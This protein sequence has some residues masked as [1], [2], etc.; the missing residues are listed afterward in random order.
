VNHYLSIDAGLTPVPYWH[1]LGMQADMPSAL[2]VRTAMT[3]KISFSEYVMEVW[4]QCHDGLI[5]E[6]EMAG[7]ITAALSENNHLVAAPTNDTNEIG[8]S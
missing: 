8:I 3:D 6:T 7:K 4:T 2:T 5:T 1:M